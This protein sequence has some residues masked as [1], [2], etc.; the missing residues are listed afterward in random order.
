MMLV[1][2]FLIQNHEIMFSKFKSMCL[3]FYEFVETARSEIYLPIHYATLCDID[4]H[5][6]QLFFSSVDNQI[7]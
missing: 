5:E 1:A 3:I 2:K 6:T 7:N 4:S